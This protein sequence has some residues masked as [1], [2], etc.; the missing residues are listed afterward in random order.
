MR[1]CATCAQSCGATAC[2]AV[3][4]VARAPVSRFQAGGRAA[5]DVHAQLH[6]HVAVDAPRANAVNVGFYLDP[7]VVFDV[8]RASGVNG[9]V[10]V[11]VDVSRC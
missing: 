5:D 11:R 4:I 1:Y 8:D 2:E 9:G 6:L 3:E 10:D 7:G